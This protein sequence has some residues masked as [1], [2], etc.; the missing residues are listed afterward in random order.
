MTEQLRHA[1]S[2][3]SL[4]EHRE[5]PMRLI[6]RTLGVKIAAA[7]HNPGTSLPEQA[8][9]AIEHLFDGHSIALPAIE[10][11]TALGHEVAGLI[12][13]DDCYDDEALMAA[14]GVGAALA[15][16]FDGA[17]TLRANGWFTG[18]SI[19]QNN[20]EL[21]L[22]GGQCQRCKVNPIVATA[23]FSSG[24]RCLDDKA[25]RWWACA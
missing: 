13:A 18:Q 21:R 10:D 12:A 4:T 2:L 1:T 23:G 8:S 22:A 7:R 14:R 9:S 16:A 17:T 3:M 11:F 15:R 6:A 5:V 20:Q 19:F 24:V 25:C